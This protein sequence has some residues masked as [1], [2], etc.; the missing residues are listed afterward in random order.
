MVPVLRSVLMIG[1]S[2][3]TASPRSRA[4]VANWIKVR[5]SML[6]SWWFC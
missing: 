2:A 4:G 6:S 1:S 5:S 3:L